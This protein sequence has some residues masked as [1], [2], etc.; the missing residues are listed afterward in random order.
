MLE[1]TP[2]VADTWSTTL[3]HGDMLILYVRSLFHIDGLFEALLT[4]NPI[5]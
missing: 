1:D 2:D 4:Y 3:R 5:D